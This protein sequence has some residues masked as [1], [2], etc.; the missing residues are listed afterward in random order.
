MKKALVILSGGQD[1]VTCLF[2]AIQKGYE[3]SAIT[4]DYEQLHRIEIESAKKVC[5]IAGIENHEILSMGPLFS[6]E[7]PLTNKKVSLDKYSSLDEV[8]PGIQRTFVPGGNLLFLT[9]AA[10]RAYSSNIDTM[11]TGICEEDFG[12][13]PDCRKDFIESLEETIFLGLERKITILTPLMNMK[14]SEIV[15]LAKKL[16]KNCWEALSFSHTSY[17]GKYP[18]TSNDHANLLRAKGFEEAGYPDPLVERA[19]RE[20]LMERP[21]TK[22]YENKD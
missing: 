13:Y 14:K 11:I 9:L 15:L 16:P 22:N 4:F 1:S 5:K 17:D 8:S 2:W 19:I 10:N 21:K 3:C 6:G 12:G 20:N 7:S 18:P